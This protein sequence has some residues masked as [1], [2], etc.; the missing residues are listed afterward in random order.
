MTNLEKIDALK[1]EKRLELI[2]SIAKKNLKG[3]IAPSNFKTAVHK[4]AENDDT[5]AFL[6]QSVEGLKDFKIYEKPDENVL[7]EMFG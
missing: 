3:K 1:S 4:L 2:A 6:A 7:S 5:S